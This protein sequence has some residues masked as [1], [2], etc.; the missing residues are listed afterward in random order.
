MALLEKNVRRILAGGNVHLHIDLIAGLPEEDFD[1]FGQS[2]NKAF[3]LQPHQL[4][5]GFLKLIYGSRLREEEW[6]VR[7]SPD[8]PYEVLSTP[9]MT[10]P[11]L[12]RLNACAEAV[13]KLHNSGRFAQVLQLALT[14]LRITPFE[15]FLHLGDAMAQRAGRWSLDGLT[16]LVFRRLTGMGLDEQEVRDAMVRDRLATDNTGYLQPVL[17]SSGDGLK[18]ASRWYKETYPQVRRPRLALL[19]GGRTLLVARWETKHPVTERGETEE[20]SLE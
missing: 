12:R 1:T 18:Q 16:E 20:I 9:W 4:Q 2:F 15:L 17:Q 3:G 10:Y 6:G 19:H 14:K 11:Q 7:F 13:E 5:L 8:P